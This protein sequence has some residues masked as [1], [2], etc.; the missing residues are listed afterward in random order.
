MISRR[1]KR[2]RLM[3]CPWNDEY[4]QGCVGLVLR[5]PTRD[6][7][8]YLNRPP[9]TLEQMAFDARAGDRSDM[10]SPLGPASV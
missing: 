4:S 2:T 8:H 10:L 1:T 3:D 5:K 9:K 6:V 7:M